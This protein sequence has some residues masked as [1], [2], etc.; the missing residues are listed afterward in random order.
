MPGPQMA[1]S[2]HLKDR[3]DKRFV[4]TTARRASHLNPFDAV[5][6]SMACSCLFRVVQHDKES[7]DAIAE[8]RLELLEEGTG[9]CHPK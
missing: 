5:K 1:A 3:A 2:P 7:A 8:H 4:K 6:A 9:E